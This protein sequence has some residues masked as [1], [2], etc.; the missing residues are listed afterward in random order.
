M[1]Y[2]LQTI[3]KP[4]YKVFLYVD[5]KT[6]RI[7]AYSSKREQAN[8][9]SGTRLK[10]ESAVYFIRTRTLFSF[11]WANTLNWVVTKAKTSYSALF[12]ITYVLSEH[13]PG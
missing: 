10:T 11:D 7:F 13:F 5:C 6:V 2:V 3:V 9:R 1:I 12:I 8:K 4:T